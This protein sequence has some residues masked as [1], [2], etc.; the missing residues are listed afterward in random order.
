MKDAPAAWFRLEPDRP[1]H[2]FDELLRDGQA[3]VR[4]RRVSARRSRRPERT[5]G[6]SGRGKRARYPA[7]C[8]HRDSNRLRRAASTSIRTSAPSGRTSRRWTA[9]STAP[10]RAAGCP[11]PPGRR[12]RSSRSRSASPKCGCVPLVVPDRLLD[13]GHHVVWL[14]EDRQAAVDQLLQVEQ[15]VDQGAESLAV[16][17]RDGDH[18]L[19]TLGQRPGDAGCHE[20]ER[21]GDR[22]Q[23][24]PQ[25]MADRRDELGLHPLD[26]LALADVGDDHDV[27]RHQAFRI[28]QSVCRSPRPTWLGRCCRATTCSISKGSCRSIAS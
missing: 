17:L 2:P 5:S 12:Q 6:R 20:A 1:V 13:D 26:A 7:R 15:V 8:R 23:R 21:A 24:R 28:Q 18:V 11:P 16:L 19:C 10:G 9:G 3:R 4:C 25:L 14:S 22:G 27:A